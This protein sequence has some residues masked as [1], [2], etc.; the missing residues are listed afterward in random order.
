MTGADGIVLLAVGAFVL[1][2]LAVLVAL[3]LERVW[4]PQPF[5]YRDSD[6]QELD[7]YC[8]MR[9]LGRPVDGASR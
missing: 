2:A 5:A 9:E 3:V 8:E 7:W 4:P 1:V 6:E